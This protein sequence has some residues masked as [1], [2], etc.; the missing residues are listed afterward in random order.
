MSDE[1][2]EY[3][4]LPMKEVMEKLVTPT[5]RDAIEAHELELKQRIAELEAALYDVRHWI[6]MHV[7]PGED[8][9]AETSCQR[10]L[11][12]IDT[13]IRARGGTCRGSN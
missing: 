7:D 2:K 13:A 10:M 1:P 5:L 4:V 8:R 12:R 11:D 9:S 3:M 6:A